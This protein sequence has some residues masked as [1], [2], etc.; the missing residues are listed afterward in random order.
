VQHCLVGSEMCIR[1]RSCGTPKNTY[2]IGSQ[3]ITLFDSIRSRKIPIEIYSNANPK[4]NNHQLVVMSAGYGS[5]NTEYSYIAKSLI[6]FGYLVVCVQQE[7]PN[8]PPIPSGEN[9]YKL[10]MPT[11]ERGV[12]NVEFVISAMK[13]QFQSIDNQKVILIGHSN[14]GDISMLFATLYPQKVS[15]VITLDHRRMPIPKVQKPPILSFRADEFEADKG[16]L[17]DSA[18]QKMYNIQIVNLKNTKHDDLRDIGSQELKQLVANK[19]IQF[20]NVPNN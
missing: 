6:A 8:D 19:I 3:S 17:P 7:Q 5:S 14:G 13:Q 9:I 10:R 15:K 4:V 18:T 16:V 11:W 20:L 12:Q 1:D 2:L